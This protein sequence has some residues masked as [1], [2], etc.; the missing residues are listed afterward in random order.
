M[1]FHDTEAIFT[2]SLILS[3]FHSSSFLIYFFYFC[4]SLK[5][6]F[7]FYYF[8][9]KYQFSTVL[10]RV[11]L[12]TVV[13]N[14]FFFWGGRGDFLIFWRGPWQWKMGWLPLS[15]LPCV[16]L[17]FCFWFCQF[18]ALK[19]ICA[20]ANQRKAPRR[21]IRSAA[22]FKNWKYNSTVSL[23]IGISII[24][25]FVPIFVEKFVFEWLTNVVMNT[26][27]SI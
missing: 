24:S 4:F 5:L 14:I 27:H 8:F 21:P 13:D 22:P 16:Q 9:P 17:C 2:S 10:P 23:K 26:N 1:L 11:W 12:C 6:I 19:L 25:L 18:T 3:H 20:V 15:P 7:S